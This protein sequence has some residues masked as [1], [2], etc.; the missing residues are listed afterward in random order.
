MKKSHIAIDLG[1]TNS[2]VA[3]WNDELDGPEIINLES[4]CRNT[5]KNKELDDSYTVPSCLY[6]LPP[7][8]I[9]R[10]P[11]KFLFKKLKRK[12]GGLI[13]MEALA[14][15]GGAYS[16][17]FI[18]NFKSHLG[19]NSYQFIGKLG[20]WNYTAEEVTRVFLKALVR[21]VR[22]R[23]KTQIS[24]VTFC[25]PVDFYEV[26]RAKLRRIASNLKVSK[27]KTIDEPVAAALG[28]GLSLDDP[29]VLLVI[30]FGGGTLDMAL[31]KTEQKTSERGSC[32][33][34][35]KE[36][37]PIG[38]NV[39]DAWIVEEICSKY[40]YDFELLSTDKQS[41]WWYRMLLDEACRL[42][43]TL[44]FQ[45]KETFY[46]MPSRMMDNF[47]RQIPGNLRGERENLK[48]PIDF[49]KKDLLALLEKK[50]LFS[51]FG[52]LLNNLLQSAKT[53]GIKK[54]HIDE[55]LMVGG[56]TL[57]PNIYSQVEKKFS[58]DRVRA[59][60]PFNAVAFGAAAFAANRFQKSDLITHDYA[61]VTYNKTTLDPEYNVIVPK[62]TMF[63]TP[64]DFWKR[65][66][67]PTCA[68]GEPENIFKLIICE[69]GKKHS[70]DQEFVWDEKGDLHLLKE[71]GDENALIIP[72]NESDP[73]LGYL[74]PP[75]YPSERR[76]RIE[77][78]FMINDDKWLC[79]SVYDLKT[80][81]YLLEE[82]A[83]I[84][85]K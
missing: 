54:E 53:K 80:Q 65:H 25:V 8:K 31:I 35:A 46:L 49:T 5:T 12:T 43:E 47:V 62:G 58:R 78:S 10:F 4:V 36:G 64:K 56:S 52:N 29:K 11:F 33:V 32:E 1:T 18:T 37:V 42:K 30:D 59:W 76:A 17:S 85:L 51:I 57:L 14:K 45:D 41:S 15:D 28:Y 73:T 6:L 79:S 83:V 16:P 70:F 13:G 2:V 81:K 60:Q 27:V 68:L 82:K 9:L 44:F 84:R 19:R 50:G 40:S 69:I 72:L 74:N 71:G 24:H 48:K 39:I 34:I 38:G 22:L 63:P 7:E 26:Y 77:I 55:V 21:K 67:S 61:F 20:K 23:T 3:R 75:H 66:L